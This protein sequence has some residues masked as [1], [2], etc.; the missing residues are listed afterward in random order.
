MKAINKFIFTFL[1]TLFLCFSFQSKACDLAISSFPDPNNNALI[2]FE[3]TTT[4]AVAPFTY[5]WQIGDETFPPTSNS[6]LNYEFT[7]SGIYHFC[8]IVVD[9]NGCIDDYSNYIEITIDPCPEFTIETGVDEQ[10]NLFGIIYST[11][12][13]TYQPEMTDWYYQSNNTAISSGNSFYIADLPQSGDYVIC[14]D[15]EDYL[16]D[17]S[18]CLGT[19][20]NVV[21]VVSSED[22]CSTTDCVFPGDTNEDNYADIYDILPIGLHFGSNG[23]PRLNSSNNWYGQVAQDWS[24]YT[25]EGTNLKHI[26]CNGD[27][28]INH[29]DLTAIDINFNSD[30]PY[31]P[32]IS[33]TP[34][35]LPI[36]LEFNWDSLTVNSNAPQLLDVSAN[37]I[38]GTDAI[39]ANDLYGFAAKFLFPEDMI[40]HGSFNV[41]YNPQSFF[42]ETENL[43]Q[44][45]K[46]VNDNE[47]NI[48][49]SRTNGLPV[50]GKGIVAV[51]NFTI[52]EDIVVDRS[53]G[54]N[55]TPFDVITTGVKGIT[56][57]G[58]NIPLN[59]FDNNLTIYI[60]RGTGLK[61]IP[62]AH[63]IEVGPNPTKG[64]LNINTLDFDIERIKIIN[65][66]G[67]IVQNIEVKKSIITTDLSHLANG[68]YFVE[69]ISGNQIATRKI[70]LVK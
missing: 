5:Y 57:T 40:E 66:A 17:G 68:I 45:N 6:S 23:P 53:S 58:T 62:G 67:K 69:M 27:G 50:S 47:L 21:N 26:D 1:T 33:N 61:E 35:G 48:A 41:Q 24:I 49:F 9:N 10:G 4:N 55:N 25:Q 31:T 39:P 60:D 70:T 42:C 14:A 52:I 59:T 46:V 18:I 34:N 12:D 29:N 3:A 64:N 37:L 65:T 11:N 36:Y 2:H 44:F 38:V 54:E 16:E 13:I 22:D 56:N 43:L 7:E 30:N 28:T 19:I 51:I 15:Y 63:L 8:V 32:T 20:C